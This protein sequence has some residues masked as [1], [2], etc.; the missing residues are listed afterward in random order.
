MEL[1]AEQRAFFEQTRTAVMITLRS[2]GTPHAVRIGVA[3]V[4]GKIWSSGV[5]SRVRTANLRRDPRGSLVLL[6]SGYGY[7]TI[8]AHVRILEGEDAPSQ[9]MRLFRVMQQRPEGPLLWNGE[10]LEPDAFL[11]RMAAEQRLIYEFE[12]LRV[13]G[14]GLG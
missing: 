11:E 2:D 7:L 6:P 3:L 1:S 8:E 5:P 13:Y 10:P 4:D 12:P 9:S 14:Y